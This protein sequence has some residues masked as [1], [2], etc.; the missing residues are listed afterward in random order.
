LGVSA[1]TLRR[2]CDRISAAFFAMC[3]CYDSVC[4]IISQYD[5]GFALSVPVICGFAFQPSGIPEDDDACGR[6]RRH[7]SGREDGYEVEL[8]PPPGSSLATAE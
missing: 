5:S 7:R 3:G 1:G 6:G 4:A 2:H 8:V